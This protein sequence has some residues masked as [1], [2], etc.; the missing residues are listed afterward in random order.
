MQRRIRAERM[1]PASSMRVVP[2]E[3]SFGQRTRPQ[4]RGLMPVFV[5]APGSFGKEMTPVPEYRDVFRGV[6]LCGKQLKRHPKT[7]RN[8]KWQ[9]LPVQALPDMWTQK[10]EM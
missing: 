3:F 7:S 1:T 5:Y 2:R 6:F 10:E 9:R 4:S 8:P